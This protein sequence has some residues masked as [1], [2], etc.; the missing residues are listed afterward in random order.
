M[1]VVV[2]VVGGAVAEVGAVL[3][4]VG[5]AVV[6]GADVEGVVVGELLVDDGAA[7][8][9]VPGSLFGGPLAT[10]EVG[11]LVEVVGERPPRVKGAVW[12]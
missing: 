4:D 6:L 3:V 8:L 1:R 5:G 9:L 10:D 11:A 7:V 2:V 12:V